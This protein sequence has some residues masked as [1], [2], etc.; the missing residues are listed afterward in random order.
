MNVDKV[1]AGGDTSTNSFFKLGDDVQG[2][3]VEVLHYYNRS[4]DEYYV[5]ANNILVCMGPIPF[6]HKELPVVIDYHYRIPGSIYGMG[7]P[8]VIKALSEE[9][10][11]IRNLRLDRQKMSINKMFLVNDQY[12]LDEEE[13]VTR[14]HGMIEVNTN[15]QPLRD[16][17]QALEYGDIPA[18]AYKEEETLLEDIRRA[19]G[20]DDRIQGNNVGGT[21]TE[22]AILKETSQKRINLIATLAEM[23]TLKRLGRLKWSNIQFFYPAPK[24]ERLFKDNETREKKTYRRIMIEGHSVEI[25]KGAKGNELAMNEIDG[26]TSFKLNPQLATFMEGEV[27]VTVDADSIQVVSRALQQAKITEMFAAIAS[28]P[29]FLAELDMKK[30]LRRYI[31]ANQE[32]PKDWLRGNGMRDE[33]LKMQADMENEVMKTGIP[34]APTPGANEAHTEQHLVYTQSAEFQQLPDAIQQVFVAHITGEHDA[35]PATGSSAD[36]MGSDGGGQP[37]GAN[38]AALPEVQPADMTPSTVAGEEPNSSENTNE[39]L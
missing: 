36:V 6:K 33:D 8:K 19:H 38:T 12:D 22:A 34:L 27:D 16:A 14:P 10:A 1:R 2:H 31:E 24:V 13:L 15:G 7:I 28:V 37:V 18:S 11:S 32:S 23:D 4:R 17:I 35:N 5:C 29:G 30:A 9:R 39:V 21:A 3:Q 26:S 25:V 20:I